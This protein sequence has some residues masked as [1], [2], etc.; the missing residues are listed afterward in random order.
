MN[1]LTREQLVKLRGEIM[2]CSIY[3]VD[4]E[5]SFGIDKR[6]VCDFFDGY[7][8]ELGYLMELDGLDGD[9]FFDN[10]VKY[11]NEENLWNYYCSIEC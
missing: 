3:Y 7:A 1:N 6:V 10:I 11:D 9:E 2:L 4:Y 5:N 8:E